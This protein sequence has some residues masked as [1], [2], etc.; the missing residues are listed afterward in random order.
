MHRLLRGRPVTCTQGG[1]VFG[2]GSGLGGG[3]SDLLAVPAAD[4]NLH[5]LPDEID[6]EAAL[7]LT[8]NLGT[9]WA[10]AQRADI[11]PGGTV[12]VLGI[13]AVGLCAVRSAY[14]LGAGRVLAVD[15]VAGRVERAVASGATAV[16]GPTVEAVL[17]ATQG[18]GADAVI[19]AVATDGSLT[20]A[21]AA[22]RAGGTVSVVGIHDLE[23]FPLPLL[24]GVYRSITLRMT[25]APVHRTWRDLVPL[26]VH[27]RLDTTGILTHTYDLADAAEAY[28][29]V[30]A[31]SAEVLKVRLT[32]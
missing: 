21:F 23:P 18:R 16:D 30:A 9:G 28:A 31:R 29:A 26:V 7:L 5:V 17:E 14:A 6:D 15:P 4:F 1:V 12:V 3:Q 2:S 22:V 24:M 11:P 10:G 8:D 19:D 20:D 27:G 32:T 13:G 25:T